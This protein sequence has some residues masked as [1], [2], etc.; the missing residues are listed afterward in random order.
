MSV[1][2]NDVERFRS[3]EDHNEESFIWTRN[4]KE[5]QYFRFAF[6]KYGLLDKS[7]TGKFTHPGTWKSDGTWISS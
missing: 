2:V 3:S 4:K 1:L 6:V 7:S 5:P